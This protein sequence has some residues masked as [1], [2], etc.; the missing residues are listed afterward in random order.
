MKENI[1]NIVFVIIFLILIFESISCLAREKEKKKRDI[2]TK[3][4][5]GENERSV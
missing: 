2:K 4:K 3:Q 5:G 1:E